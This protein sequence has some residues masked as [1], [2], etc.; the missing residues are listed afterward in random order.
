VSVA[1]KYVASGWTVGL[2]ASEELV[3]ELGSAFLC[4]DLELQQDAR[5]EN[6]VYSAIWLEVLKKDK[7]PSKV[8]I[9]MFGSPQESPSKGWPH[10][11]LPA[12]LRHWLEEFAPPWH[13]LVED[14]EQI[15]RRVYDL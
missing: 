14:N 13:G 6:S 3:A 1:W 4:A 10:G 9:G 11:S 12:A 2:T 8:E 7:R 15:N 5:E